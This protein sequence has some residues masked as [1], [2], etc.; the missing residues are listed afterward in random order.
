MVEFAVRDDG[1]GMT[2]ERVSR[3]FY[4]FKQADD[5]TTRKFGGTGL[6]LAPPAPS[7]G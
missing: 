5:T 2:P 3:S 4:R 6:D 7:P 1:I